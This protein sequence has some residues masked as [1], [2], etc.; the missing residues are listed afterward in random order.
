[1]LFFSINRF[2]VLDKNGINKK[3][4]WIELHTFENIIPQIYQIYENLS[5]LLNLSNLSKS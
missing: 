1:M 5:N 4:H 2:K 3:D